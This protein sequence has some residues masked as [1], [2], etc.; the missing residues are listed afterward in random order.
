MP[1][2]GVRMEVTNG[3]NLTLNEIFAKEISDVTDSIPVEQ[4]T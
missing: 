2:V 3:W 1:S 4:I